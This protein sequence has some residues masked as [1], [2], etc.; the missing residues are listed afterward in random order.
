MTLTEVLQRFNRKERHWLVRD[1]L[2]SASRHLD[3]DFLR[4]VE[5]AVRQRDPNFRMKLDAF[6]ATDFH[7]DWLV[8][9]LHVLHS[10][11]DATAPQPNEDGQVTGSQQDIDL[12]LASGSTLILI[13][14]KGVGS[15]ASQ[16]LRD[17]VDRLRHLTGSILDE[18]GRVGSIQAHFLT[19]SPGTAPDTSQS[20]WPSWMTA[21]GQPLHIPMQV[22]A[23][24]GPLYRVERCNEAGTPNAAG[25]FWHAVPD[26][27][28]NKLVQIVALSDGSEGGAELHG[29]L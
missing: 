9:A 23:E 1:A 6:W 17:K 13:E 29:S 22:V 27:Q 25:H 16:G 10:K 3:R 7:I 5:I 24:A 8:A 18:N 15:W 12:V 20:E 21:H 28:A 2:G 4:R 19:C 14:A 26:S 11:T